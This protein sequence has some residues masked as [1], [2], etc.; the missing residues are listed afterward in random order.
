MD[1]SASTGPLKVAGGTWRGRCPQ[2]DRRKHDTALAV[3]TDARGT[4]WFCHRCGFRGAKG[5]SV[6]LRRPPVSPVPVDRLTSIWRRTEP[7]KGT[8]AEKYLRH[9]H[10]L[11]P[12]L[13]SDLRYLAGSRQ[14]PPTLCGLVTDAVTGAPL[15]LQFTRLRRDGLGKAGTERDRQ[16]LKGHRKAGG[17]IR[18]WPN[19]NVTCDL[20]VAEGI[21]TSLC[22]AHAYLPV[23]AALDAGNLG[24]LPVL[25]G[26]E[27]LVIFADHDLAGLAAASSLAHR[28]R[29]AG[30]K[31][32]VLRSPTPGNDI[33]DEVA[34]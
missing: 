33:A 28:W 19:K 31:V 16:F 4:V 17:V 24:R 6:P 15:T 7:L 23:W 10:C 26:V 20:A 27:S 18:L 34:A 14:F 21:E 3:T 2:C 9:R 12:P 13:D 1:F 29:A 5:A 8:L 22:A 11:L 25:T 32:R 30:R